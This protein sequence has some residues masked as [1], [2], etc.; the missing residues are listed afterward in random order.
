MTIWRLRH[1]TIAVLKPS[2]TAPSFPTH[3]YSIDIIQ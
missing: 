3:T 1:T 2:T